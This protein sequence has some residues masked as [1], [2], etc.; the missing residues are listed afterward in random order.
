MMSIID[1]VADK[2]VFS[3]IK[4]DIIRIILHNSYE[5]LHLCFPIY[6]QFNV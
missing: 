3:M 6:H 5:K 1:V 2:G 4:M